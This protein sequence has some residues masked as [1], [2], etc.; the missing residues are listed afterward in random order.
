MLF[1]TFSVS[2][3]I[4]NFPEYFA[5]ASP[6]GFIASI[7]RPVNSSSGRDCFALGIPLCYIF[8]LLPPPVT[9]ISIDTD[10]HNFDVSDLRAKKA[11]LSLSSNMQIRQVSQYEPFTANRSSGIVIRQ[12]GWL[13]YAF[14][15]RLHLLAAWPTW[16]MAG[17][18]HSDSTGRPAP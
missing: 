1:L 14:C 15:T 9:P 6:P 12:M 5:L 17:H 7:H 8:N 2:L 18:Q 3:R 13:R 11:G 4:H 10:P 16:I